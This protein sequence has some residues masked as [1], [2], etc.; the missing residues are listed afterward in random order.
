[1]SE[2]LRIDLKVDP[3]LIEQAL[4]RMFRSA[5]NSLSGNPMSKALHAALDEANDQLL[6]MCKQEVAKFIE[7]YR[8]QIH[9]EL[10]GAM[11][12]EMQRVARGIAR[13]IAIEEAQ[14]DDR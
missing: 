12:S 5:P 13:R 3:A 6:A 2:P 10:R 11:R 1:M 9:K 7:D 8:P 14:S 4:Q